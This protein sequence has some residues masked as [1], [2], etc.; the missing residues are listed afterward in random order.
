MTYFQKYL[1]SVNMEKMFGGK[2]EQQTK[3]EF[4]SIANTS[5]M[6][7]P[8]TWNMQNNQFYRWPLILK[9]VKLI[10]LRKLILLLGLKSI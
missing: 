1:D 6:H 2:I 4:V 10:L 7:Y 9:L 3:S 8:L 5:S